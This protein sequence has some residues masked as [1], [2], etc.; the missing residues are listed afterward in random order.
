MQPVDYSRTAFVS[1]SHQQYYDHHS[2]YALPAPSS[3]YGNYIQSHQRQQD[4]SQWS[5]GSNASTSHHR[6]HQ[7][8]S[9]SPAHSNSSLPLAVSNLHSG[10]YL[11]QPP[12]PL[13]NPQWPSQPSPYVKTE[14]YVKNDSYMKSDTT[15]SEGSPAYSYAATDTSEPPPSSSANVSLPPPRRRVSPGN[16]REQYG[17]GGRSADNRPVG[18]LKCSSC[19]TTQSA[20]WRKGPSRK[21]ELRKLII[22]L[23]SSMAQSVLS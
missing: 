2:P 18:I 11:P 23:F 15:A 4:S 1:Q 5:P 17:P 21:K 3:Q 10:S 20:E 7:C 14:L 6:T 22:D 16:T 9:P 8:H 19:N 12:P 13:P